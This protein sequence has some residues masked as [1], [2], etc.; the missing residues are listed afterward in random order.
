[1]TDIGHGTGWASRVLGPASG[2]L[3]AGELPHSSETPTTTP[4]SPQAPRSLEGVGEYLP[5]PT[6]YRWRDG[7][8]GGQETP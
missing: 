4:F 2:T 7:G 8:Q 1:M 3:P 6:V 5:L